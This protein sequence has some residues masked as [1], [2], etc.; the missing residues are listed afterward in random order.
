[1]SLHEVFERQE[2][3]PELVPRPHNVEVRLHLEGAI[4]E[5][6]A[7]LS[8]VA[9]V[10]PR[11]EVI[12]GTRFARLRAGRATVKTAP[13]VEMAGSDGERSV[14][15]LT[16]RLAVYVEGQV[17]VPADRLVAILK[18]A[19]ESQAS[20]EVQ[21]Q[22]LTVRSG[23]ALW[24]VALP[25]GTDLPVQY[26]PWSEPLHSVGR[27]VF[28]NSLVAVAVATGDPQGRPSMAQ[29]QIKN[30]TMLSC[31]GIRIHRIHV[32]DLPD[33]EFSIPSSAL[34]ELIQALK[35]G[36][37]EDISLGANDRLVEVEVDTT[38]MTIQQLAVPFPASVE[39]IITTAA[40]SN[41]DSL[42]VDTTM[43]KD[44]VSRVRVNAD[45]DHAQINLTVLA[46]A[47]GHDLIVHARDRNGNAA[48]EV[49]G[50]Q[51]FGAKRNV[52]LVL[53]KQHLTDLLSVFGQDMLP[54][55]L[56]AD[57]VTRSGAIYAEDSEVGLTVVLQQMQAVR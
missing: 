29:V 26:K 40:I 18:R 17:L 32:P 46:V 49:M 23:R 36:T 34:P 56:G 30:R 3:D 52:D 14:R 37:G 7:V 21:G 5:F 45:P 35:S 22:A 54:L 48:Q 50:C 27:E 53:H 43:L 55:R 2:A 4:K 20:V 6:L 51:Y 25:S 33:I 38:R 9:A 41:T 15:S 44:A 19:P 10:V 1:M 13:F 24:T 42:V 8:P 12:P 11:R 39:S 16:D 28:L 31:D 57:T 47:T